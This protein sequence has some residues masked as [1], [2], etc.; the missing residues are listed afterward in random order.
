MYLSR[1]DGAK[2]VESGYPVWYSLFLREFSCIE[3]LL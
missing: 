2:M 1:K 3:M